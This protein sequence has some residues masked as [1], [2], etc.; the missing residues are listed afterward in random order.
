MCSPIGD[1]STRP[2]EINQYDIIMVTH[3]NI[4][5]GNVIVRNVNYD[6]T[7]MLLGASILMSH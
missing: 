1:Q 6:I 2:V 7:M 3:Y 4:T 5:M